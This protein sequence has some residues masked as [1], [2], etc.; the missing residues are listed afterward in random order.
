MGETDRFGLE[1]L[2]GGG[3]VYSEKKIGDLFAALA[4]L[5]SRCLGCPGRHIVLICSCCYHKEPQP[6][7][8]KQM[9]IS[10]SSEG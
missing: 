9:F 1:E 7:C 8:L 3:A 6:G 10:H 4:I 2:G 5:P